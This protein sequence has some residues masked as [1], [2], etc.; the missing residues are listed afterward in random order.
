M[1]TGG[2]IRPCNAL[3][4]RRELL[5]STTFF[6]GQLDCNKQYCEFQSKPHTPARSRHE[7]RGGMYGTVVGHAHAATCRRGDHL[8]GDNGGKRL[9]PA[10]WM[11]RSPSAYCPRCLLSMACIR[12]RSSSRETPA[13]S[14]RTFEPAPLFCNPHAAVVAQRLVLTLSESLADARL[15]LVHQNESAGVRL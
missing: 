6:P 9:F 4:P 11:T 10:V 12:L 7:L 5:Q 15:P 3:P 2:S 13:V 1:P 14:P 8:R